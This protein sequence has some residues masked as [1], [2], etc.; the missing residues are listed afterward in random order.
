MK[1]GNKIEDMEKKY[2]IAT[3]FVCIIKNRRQKNAPE[4]VQEME[5]KKTGKEP[6]QKQQDAVRLCLA[7]LITA[8]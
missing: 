7:A 6:R 1:C 5:K 8:N 4:R 2:G 3:K